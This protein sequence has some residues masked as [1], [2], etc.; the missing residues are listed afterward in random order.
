MAKGKFLL[1]ADDCEDD[2]LLLKV[3][4]RRAGLPHRLFHV[5]DGDHAIMY[6][7]GSSAFS[8]R[9]R[10]PFPD[11]LVLDIQMPHGNGFQ[12]LS[13]L[14]NYPEIQVPVVMFSASN[15]PSDMQLAAELGATYF[16][17]KPI[18]LQATVELAQ[19]MDERWLRKPAQDSSHAPRSESN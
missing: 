8:D 17:T 6:L 13:I 9:R 7:E 4:F 12:V 2:F 1:V 3:S 10:F 16:F 19:T 14:R 15:L 11:L 5:E 18:S